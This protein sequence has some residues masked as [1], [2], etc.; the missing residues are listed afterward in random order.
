[1]KTG[2]MANCY[3]SSLTFFGNI[4]SQLQTGKSASQQENQADQATKS[5]NVES[6]IEKHIAEIETEL[7]TLTQKSI[8]LEKSKR[9][10]HLAE[11]AMLLL[12]LYF[13]YMVY[14]SKYSSVKLQY[15]SLFEINCHTIRSFIATR[16]LIMSY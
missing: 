15:N 13:I 12:W 9:L 5:N 6:E 10:K 8:K 2:S 11:G 1:M 3:S 14:K 7:N 4:F 16:F